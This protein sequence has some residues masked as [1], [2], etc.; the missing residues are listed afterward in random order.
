MLSQVKK[1]MDPAGRKD[2]AGR[3]GAWWDGREYVPEAEADENAAK[4]GAAEPEDPAGEDDLFEAE[5]ESASDKPAI[6][7]AT[8]STDGARITALERLWGVGNFGPN[9][10]ASEILDALSYE[11]MAEGDIGMMGADPAL[12]RAWTRRS[13]R[14]LYASEWRTD[15]LPRVRRAVPDVTAINDDIDRAKAFEDDTLAALASI[16]TMAYADHKAGLV[17]RAF[18]ALKDG[19]KWVIFDTVRTTAKT[20]AT[21]FASA[22]AEP[23]LVEESEVEAL[24][25][26]AGFA[27]ISKINVTA[28][29]IETARARMQDLGSALETTVAEGMSGSEGVLFLRELVWELKSWRARLKALEG[30][31][32]Q[33]VLWSAVKGGKHEDEPSSEAA[34]QPEAQA[35]AAQHDAAPS[36][37]EPT[38]EVAADKEE[39]SDADMTAR[40]KAMVAAASDSEEPADDADLDDS[41]FEKPE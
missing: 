32:L 19:G 5:G 20:P 29:V 35:E 22:W 27:E 40:I 6:P 14:D 41:L 2:V 12:L 3:F 30:G 39:R 7:L 38:E 25:E 4:A 15:A 13:A 23:Q 21:A 18:H 33:V 36:E 31:A 37:P 11:L 16:N 1:I 26:K 34:D 17:S 24:L 8:A 9:A 28:N 10:C